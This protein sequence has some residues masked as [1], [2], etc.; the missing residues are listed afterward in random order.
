[1]YEKTHCLI[2]SFQDVFD[3][4]FLFFFLLYSS[5]FQ[6]KVILSYFLFVLW[7]LE[8]QFSFFSKF[9][10]KHELNKSWNSLQYKSIY[11]T[12][13]GKKDVICKLL[14]PHVEYKV[15]LGKYTTTSPY[16]APY[17]GVKDIIHKRK[18]KKMTVFEWNCFSSSK[19]HIAKIFA[20]KLI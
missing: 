9:Y 1:M 14:H 18:T 19:A 15:L 8:Q 11:K 16:E 4:L 20:M 13:F 10:K 7:L 17:E 6:F 5:P 2:Y 12:L 3:F